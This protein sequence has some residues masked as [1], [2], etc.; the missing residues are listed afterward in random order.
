MLPRLRARMLIVWP[1]TGV[2]LGVGFFWDSSSKLTLAMLT[3]GTLNPE[4][5]IWSFV[6]ALDFVPS[7]FRS[8]WGFRVLELGAV[9]VQLREGVVLP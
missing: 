2:L 4:P 7:F 1:C 5:Q 8:Y 6:G 9:F 3:S